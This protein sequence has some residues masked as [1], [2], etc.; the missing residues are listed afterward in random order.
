MR[1]WGC[2]ARVT[3][4]PSARHYERRNGCSVGCKQAAAWAPGEPRRTPALQPVAKPHPSIQHCSG[5]ARARGGVQRGREAAWPPGRRDGRAAVS[6]WAGGW[7]CVIRATN[8]GV[9]SQQP[10]HA[11]PAIPHEHHQE[12]IGS[13]AATDDDRSGHWAR[14]R[15]HADPEW[16]AQAGN[17]VSKGSGTGHNAM[18]E[19][20]PGHHRRHEAGSREHGGSCC[21]VLHAGRGGQPRKQLR[22][23]PRA[24]A[25]GRHPDGT[26]PLLQLQ[27][28]GANACTCPSVP[29]RVCLRGSWPHPMPS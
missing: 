24:L 9:A 27:V 10:P 7:L 6:S 20:T 1:Q 2:Q 4:P 28:A 16:R 11:H 17:C 18:R 13:G 5:I 8:R 22:G 12:N 23:Q 14:A 29:A 21:T 3:A 25:L 19:R 15:E 26:G